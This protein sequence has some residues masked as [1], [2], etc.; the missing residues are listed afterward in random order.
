MASIVSAGTTSATAL[1]M[2]A[3]TTGILQLASNN[4]TVGLTIDT[5]QNVGINN[6][7]PTIRTKL[8]VSSSN[9]SDTLTVG[10]VSGGF[11][12]TNTNSAY[13]LQFGSLSTGNS[14]IQSARM[15]GTATAYNLLLQYGGGNVGVNCIPAVALDVTR[16]QNALTALNV[17][18][19][20][21]TNASSIAAIRVGYDSTYHYSI[22]R[23]GNSADIIHNATQSSANLLWQSAGSTRMTLAST[24]YLT[25]Q[26][27]DS[28][29]NT[30]TLLGDGS[31]AGYA[32]ATNWNTGAS[33]LDF[34]LGGQ[35]TSYTKMRINNSGYAYLN[36]LTA[37][38]P[39]QAIL[40]VAG[41]NSIPGI[42][43]LG[44]TGPWAMKIGTSD[45]GAT[46]YIL[47]VCNSGSATL[48]GITTNG[49]VITYGGTSD[50][51]LKDV[52]GALTGYK[53]RLSALKPKQGTWKEN[54][55]EFRGFLAHEF[56][57]SYP[58]SVAGEK[59]A[60]DADGNPKYQ[61]MQAGSSEV[62][63]DMVAYINELE[64]RLTALE[65]K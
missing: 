40:S 34:R 65:N 10:T 46:R 12:I 9:A 25:L 50:Y 5:S 11:S 1:N 51:R 27:T 4:G 58:S 17:F 49:T 59:D 62:I 48:G 37:L 60:V 42:T 38:G 36:T 15:D 32:L 22:S 2:S 23:V 29:G 41:T 24:G 26:T 47:G 21:S 43:V 52:S 14:W 44:G 64:T 16:N 33:Y 56:A 13:G 7:S 28:A 45:A 54:G 8:M 35:T 57:N 30:A 19:S 63:A 55:S 6:S 61:S 39:D 3:D 31:T 18:N 53:E 20:D